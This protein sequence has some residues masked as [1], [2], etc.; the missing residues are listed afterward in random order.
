MGEKNRMV[1]TNG[2]EPHRKSLK[3]MKV[4]LL[5]SN[6]FNISIKDIHLQ[7]GDG[8]RLLECGMFY[9]KIYLQ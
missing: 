8:A 4:L 3:K 5:T 2:F 6:Y 1:E 9:F 7:K